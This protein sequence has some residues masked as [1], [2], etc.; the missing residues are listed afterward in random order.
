MVLSLPAHFAH[1]NYS[2]WLDE[3]W[4][5]NS[6]LQPT[7]YDVYHN[8]A[9]PQLTPPLFLLLER[10]MAGMVGS[11][12]PALRILP[13]AACLIGTVLA[14]V[15]FRRWLPTWAA[16]LALTLLCTNYYVL[17]YS[18][19][20]KQYGGDLLIS[21][22]LLLLVGR[23]LENRSQRNFLALLVAQ[24][25]VLFLSHTAAFWLPTVLVTV[26]L[27]G[28]SDEAGPVGLRRFRL[29]RAAAAGC[30]LGAAF[31]VLYINFVRP[32][33]IPALTNYFDL[34]Y[35]DPRHPLFSLHR[36][37]STVGLILSTRRGRVADIVGTIAV[38]LI[39]YAAVRALLHLRTAG[40]GDQRDLML[41]LGGAL[42]LACVIAA[43]AA[44]L[45]PVLDYPRM[46]LWALPSAALLLGDGANSVLTWMGRNE[47]FQAAVP[48]MVAWAC[49]AAVL[50]TQIIFIRYPP[51]TEENRPAIAFIKGH[52]NPQDL[53][54]VHPGMLEQ[55]KYYRTALGFWP[56]HVYIG[57]GEWPCC[58]TGNFEEVSSPGLQDYRNDLLEAARR[59]KG[60]DLWLLSP[61][62]LEGAW[63]S[64]FRSEL[65][66]FPAVLAEGGCQREVHRL[67]GETKV[68]SYSCR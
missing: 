44:R 30:V 33:R 35:L 24:L 16:L 67:F 53:V 10:S 9:W 32:N 1:L 21:A 54:F 37:I 19:Q 12:E 58:P 13:L 5:A 60:Y 52:M 29:G 63:A 4:V 55:F 14:A 8:K 43:G 66:S 41:V 64:T 51:V 50:A 68:E 22:L 36:L 65:E 15:V 57:N 27:P 6:F 48:V 20:V 59:A 2:I 49:I 31:L 40:L 25:A 42:P 18:Q 46:L 56:E 39:T 61:A 38:A 62:G 26:S 7:L 3:A 45:Y 23:Y 34:Q 28:P 11:S 17:K 47:A